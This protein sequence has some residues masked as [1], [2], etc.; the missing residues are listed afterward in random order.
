MKNRRWD[1]KEWYGNPE[2]TLQDIGWSA[3][4]KLQSG[5]KKY[6]KWQEKVSYS[7]LPAGLPKS[8][9]SKQRTFVG[10]NNHRNKRHDGF[11]RRKH[12][13]DSR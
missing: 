6:F 12:G 3:K 11:K 10:Y 9:V 4:T 2:K 13:D 7:E 5:L 1:L 8:R